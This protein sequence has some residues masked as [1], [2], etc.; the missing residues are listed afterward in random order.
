MSTDQHNELLRKIEEISE[1]MELMDEKLNPIYDTYS[2]WLT[3]GRWG[4]MVLYL[5]GAILGLVVAWRNI[6]K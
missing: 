4:K 1:K 6:F 2:A 5:A 3:L